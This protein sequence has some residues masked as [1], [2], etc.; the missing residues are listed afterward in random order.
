MIPAQA[1]ISA[2]TNDFE[3]PSSTSLGKPSRS[4][5]AFMVTGW[6]PSSLAASEREIS[7][8]AVG[9]TASVMIFFAI[10]YLVRRGANH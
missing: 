4:I 7:S 3:R 6:M 10:S 5:S 1:S 2:R 8:G 9:S